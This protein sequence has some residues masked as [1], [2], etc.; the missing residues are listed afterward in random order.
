VAGSEIGFVSGTT[1]ELTKV[2]NQVGRE[3]VQKYVMAA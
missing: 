2:K 1:E 3:V